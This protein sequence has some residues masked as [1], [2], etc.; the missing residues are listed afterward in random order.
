MQ[1]AYARLLL[2]LVVAG[3]LSSLAGLL[4]MRIVENTPCDGER[5]GCN[6]DQAVGAY[7]VLIYAV[8]GPIIFAVTLGIARNRRALAGATIVL[9]A[10]LVV[11]FFISSIEHWRY[12]GFDAY[13]EWRKFLVTFMP[14]ILAVLVQSLVLRAV[15][16][17]D[18]NLPDAPI[19]PFKQFPEK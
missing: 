9:L 15:T 1:R 6:I 7:A 13:S 18:R 8:L 3:V 14:S 11:F 17:S 16:G 2:T 5:L 4:F 12:V 19:S 10:P